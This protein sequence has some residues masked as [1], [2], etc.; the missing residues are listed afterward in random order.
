MQ[1]TIYYNIN[2]QHRIEKNYKLIIKNY[3]LHKRNKYKLIRLA[4]NEKKN[5]C[6]IGL[7]FTFEIKILFFIFF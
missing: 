3:S 1:T 6:I 5:Y 7:L 2:K 4:K